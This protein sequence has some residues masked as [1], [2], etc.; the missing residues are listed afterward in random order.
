MCIGRNAI[1]VNFGATLELNEAD[2][3]N[4]EGL[5]KQAKILITTMVVRPETSLHA[6]KVAKRHGRKFDLYLVFID[7]QSN[8]FS[9]IQSENDLQLR[10]SHHRLESG[11]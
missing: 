3:E 7:F 9:S 6:L 1:A 4:A 2:I 10:A 5:I 11:V 8:R